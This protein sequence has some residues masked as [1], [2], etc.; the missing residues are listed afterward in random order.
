MVENDLRLETISNK[1]IIRQQKSEITVQK[2]RILA[3]I[4]NERSLTCQANDLKVLKDEL[5]VCKSWIDVKEK[6]RFE[7]IVR[8]KGLIKEDST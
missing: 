8:Y 1:K 5:W 3:I 7:W 2:S 4:I 6:N